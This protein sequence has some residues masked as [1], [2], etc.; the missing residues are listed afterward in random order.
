MERGLKT[1]GACELA[2]AKRLKGPPKLKGSRLYPE[3]S[4]V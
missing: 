2:L 4:D 1:C 3:D